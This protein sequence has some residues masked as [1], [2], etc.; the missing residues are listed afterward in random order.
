M[1]WGR[2][3]QSPVCPCLARPALS[4]H[5]PRAPVLSLRCPGVRMSPPRPRRTGPAAPASAR[6]PGGAT[7]G[8][9]RRLRPEAPPA[10]PRRPARARRVPAEGGSGRRRSTPGVCS[11]PAARTRGTMSG[12]GALRTL[13][14]RPRPHVARRPRPTHCLAPEPIAARQPMAGMAA[15]KGSGSGARRKLACCDRALPAALPQQP[16]LC[17]SAG[18]TARVLPYDGARAEGTP[19]CGHLG[20]PSSLPCPHRAMDTTVRLLMVAAVVALRNTRWV[21]GKVLSGAALG[22]RA[23]SPAIHL[24]LDFQSPLCPRV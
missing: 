7:A 8:A 6:P 10:R 20:C 14:S 19:G 13:A 18:V 12:I 9:V 5:C 2:C 23:Q 3:L 21:M 11:E 16:P 1:W 17:P 4:P 24:G 22:S 15:P